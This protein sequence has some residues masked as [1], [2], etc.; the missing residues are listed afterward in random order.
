M[1]KYLLEIDGKKYEV[2]VDLSG[3][4]PNVI[5]NGKKIDVKVSSDTSS[6]E[7]IKQVKKSPKKVSETK[8]NT[9]PESSNDPGDLKALMPGKVTKVIVS[10][11]Q[12]VKVG[13]PVILMESMKMEQTIV[14][15]KDGKISDINVSE[16]DTVE[17]GKIMIK[18][19]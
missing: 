16:G 12:N 15:T 9:I 6:T 7:N 14:A 4:K 5:V 17:V 8:L 2:E 3:S 13:E 1:K 11:G 10:N 19:T 18:I